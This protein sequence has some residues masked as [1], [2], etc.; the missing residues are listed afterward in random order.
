MPP[1]HPRALDHRALRRSGLMA[2]GALVARRV[3]RELEFGGVWGN[4][5]AMA[6]ERG[7]DPAPEG[8]PTYRWPWFVLGAVVLGVVLAILWMAQEVR[9]TRRIR[10]LNTP[11]AA[12]QAP[13]VRTL[14][15]VRMDLP[16]QA[17]GVWRARA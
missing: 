8:A 4:G 14:A 2:D 1:A 7:T 6:D 12:G 10:E 9:R 17:P 5:D 3:R 15:G 11:P 13:E 16:G